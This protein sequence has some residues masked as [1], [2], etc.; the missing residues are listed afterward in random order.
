[1][2]FFKSHAIKYKGYKVITVPDKFDDIRA[3]AFKGITPEYI[4]FSENTKSIRNYAFSGLSE[5]NIILPDSVCEIETMA[6]ND[7]GS[8]VVIYCNQ[9]S[10]ADKVCSDI[11]IEI[12]YE[13]LDIHALQ[14]EQEKMLV[15]PEPVQIIEEMPI[16]EIEEKSSA[17]PE[18][19]PSETIT[20]INVTE[21]TA[22][23][24]E[25]IDKIIELTENVTGF[26]DSVAETAVNTTAAPSISEET[27]AIIEENTEVVAD[28]NASIP[29]IE[30]VDTSSENDMI[31]E[32]EVITETPGD[33][34]TYGAEQQTNYN[35]DNHVNTTD[36][37]TVYIFDDMHAQPMRDVR[38]VMYDEHSGVSESMVR[39]EGLPDKTKEYVLDYE[40]FLHCKYVD[41]NR[42]TNIIS[43]AEF[44]FLT[45]S[46]QHKSANMANT[47]NMA[48]M[49]HTALKCPYC[50][51]NIGADD[52]YCAMCGRKV[53]NITNC[54]R[55]NEP[56]DAN[57]N[58][59]AYCGQRL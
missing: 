26:T 12:S 44:D 56:N 3:D 45:N 54:P 41:G 42:I 1:M 23:I 24:S 28:D 31:T 59:C 11:G 15:K 51:E 27:T 38:V 19:E 52:V 50:N 46:M 2:K 7:M 4:I 58:F 8:D 36:N 32:N 34:T 18:N 33:N 6:F 21:T 20:E 48:N 47:A 14:E 9:G 55:C 39:Y 16:V 37:G 10:F 5:C 43:K 53:K 57:D 35:V 49:A 30:G 25:S 22:T 40:L 17:I 29:K 13:K